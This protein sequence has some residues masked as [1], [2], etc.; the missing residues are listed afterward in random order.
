MSRRQI[1]KSVGENGN[2]EFLDSRTV[3]ELLHFVP[4]IEGGP[5]L[6]VVDGICGPKTKKAIKEFQIKQFGIQFADGK[7]DPGKRSIE[8]LKQFEEKNGVFS[9]TVCR[10][11]YSPLE[12]PRTDKT[13]DRFYLIEGGGHSTI[14]C[15]TPQGKIKPQTI[16]IKRAQSSRQRFSFKTEQPRTSMLFQTGFCLHAEATG[17]VEG[18][19]LDTANIFLTNDQ[20]WEVV[21]MR[22]R[23][24]W[25]APAAHS[26]STAQEHGVFHIVKS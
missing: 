7:V 16:E 17:D 19:S 26:Y 25:A 1:S 10:L 9:F 22:M 8:R 5:G 13:L 14:Y 12:R 6:L 23:H 18:G 3:Q 15:W 21:S 2:N 20:N 24:K 11:E 4:I